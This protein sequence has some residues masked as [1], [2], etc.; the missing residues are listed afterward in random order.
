MPNHRLW[1]GNG[2]ASYWDE[3]LETM[4]REKIKEL[5]LKL[6][7]ET[8]E[9]AYHNSDYYRTTFA[10]AGVSPENLHSL[11]DLKKFPFI[12]KKILRKRQEVVPPYGDLVC[13]P[14]DDLVYLS[15][16]SGSTG[17]PTASPFTWQDFEDWQD[18]E[19]R[20]FWSSG[21]RPTDI[22]CHSLQFTLFVGGPDVVGAMKV[23]ALSIW[24]G[25][26]PSERLLDIFQK[27]KPTAIWTTPSYAW[28]LGETAQGQGVD[29]MRD[30]A[31]RRIFVAGEPGGSIPETR[32]R[33]E[34]LWGAELY[35]YYGLSD[36]FGACAGMCEAK[37]GLHWAEDHIL[38]EVL[39]PD[40]GEE[41]KEGERG[42]LVITSLRK[43]AR[44]LIR[45][46]TGDIVSHT[47]EPCSCG[48]THLR[49]HGIHGRVDDMLII[50][51]VNVFP[52][53]IEKVVRQNEDLTGEY[54]LVVN[55][56][57]HLA[58]LT[59]EVEQAEGYNASAD[60][61]EHEVVSDIFK[62]LGIKPR[63]KIL[64]PNTLERATHKA[65]RV[66]D[67]RK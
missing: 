61:L 14:H 7:Q 35:D 10:A 67:E 51:G 43:K 24:A 34:A 42:E 17:V 38:V 54:R 62:I 52:S 4:P 3:E 18:Y 2:Y 46:R 64:P 15:A 47:T 13:V 22:Y 1:R 53:D 31:V 48:R 58:V 11:D 33:I 26:I 9:L 19:A 21:L 39:N 5:Q 57:K 55:E 60:R 41:V 16:S 50:R 36:I 44:P 40:T 30:L 28:Y 20:L 45:F 32:Q 56:E 49:L 6:L 29:P 65:K 59:V 23:G 25:A 37:N 63:V 66:F 8:V 27:W 12:D